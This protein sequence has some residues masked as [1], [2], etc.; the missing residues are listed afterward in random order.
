[1]RSRNEQRA[2]EPPAFHLATA[3][4]ETVRPRRRRRPPRPRQHAIW[5]P[6]WFERARGLLGMTFLIVVAGIAVA[7]AFALTLLAV[8]VFVATAFN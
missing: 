5:T 7:A 8:A 1:M 4:V 6:A 3:P 2:T